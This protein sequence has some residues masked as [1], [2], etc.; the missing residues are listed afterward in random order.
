MTTED[1]HHELIALFFPE[2]MSFEFHTLPAD[3]DYKPPHH[4]TYSKTQNCLIWSV[5]YEGENCLD[6]C[7]SLYEKVRNSFGF[8]LSDLERTLK[9]RFLSRD[10]SDYFRRFV[11]N[12]K[13]SNH[14]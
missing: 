11:E 6:A 13:R 9:K 10:S 1:N 3:K 7:T 5:I 8:T 14:K 2:T 4:F 12:L